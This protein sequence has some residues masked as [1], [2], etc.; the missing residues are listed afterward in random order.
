MTTMITR[1]RRVDHT[2]RGF[3]LIEL[4]V[5][6]AIIAVLIAML[7]PAVQQAREAAR[8]SSCKSN[9]HNI[10]LAAHNFHSRFGRFPPGYLGPNTTSYT[11]TDSNQPY[12]GVLEFLLADLE[13]DNV[14]NLIP[15]SRFNIDVLGGPRWE[16]NAATSTSG[17]TQ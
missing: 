9:L 16:T 2:R 7:L 1:M 3:T 15:E 5:V 10:A 11:S 17:A 8:R 12:L 13:Q 4:L 14:R 6:I